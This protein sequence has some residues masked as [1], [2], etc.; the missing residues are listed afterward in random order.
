METVAY[1]VAAL[2][3]NYFKNNLGKNDIIAYVNRS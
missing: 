1:D 2:L 3:N